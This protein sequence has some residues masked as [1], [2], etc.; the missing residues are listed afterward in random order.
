MTDSNQTAVDYE[1]ADCIGMHEHG[2]YCKAMG[3]LQPG[4]PLP[5]EDRPLFVPCEVCGTEGRIF[6]SRYGGNDPDVW[7]AGPCPV[8]HGA[9]VVDVPSEPITLED[10]AND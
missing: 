4:G 7:D 3:A 9:C 2:C 5:S 6:T 10:I 1:C 8:C